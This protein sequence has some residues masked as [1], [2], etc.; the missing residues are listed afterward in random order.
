VSQPA[1]SKQ[2]ATL[3][4][5]LG[6]TLFERS[7]RGVVITPSGERLVAQ[8]RR[9]LA[10]VDTLMAF[11]REEGDGLD[12]R[13]RLGVIPTIGPYLLPNALLQLRASH[14]ALHLLLR[15]DLTERLLDRLG[16]GRLD[17]AVVALPLPRAGFATATL[18]KEQFLL[19]APVGHPLAHDDGPVT[20]AD[21]VGHR[22]ILLEEGHC[23]R[24][25]ALAVCRQAG[26]GAAEISGTS[27]GTVVQMVA[28]GLGV[29]LLP[30]RA[31]DIEVRADD[32]IVLRPFVPPAPQR[33]VALA[34]RASSPR[35]ETFV[36][37][38]D[39]LREC[40]RHAHDQDESVVNAA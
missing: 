28:N 13:L 25:Q 9:V 39:A 18:Y 20:D 1:L 24:D 17:A 31:A 4:A 11:A 7:N 2:L 35:G 36:A 3:E 32:P 5:R 26:A 6:T 23:L 27:L 12:G 22:L 33:T 40:T 15:E 19:A 29:T 16:D 30:A 37:L 10:E 21:L 38:A 8:A 34:W 14:P